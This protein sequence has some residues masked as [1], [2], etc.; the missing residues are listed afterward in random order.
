[1][2]KTYQAPVI[3]VVDLQTE[4]VM[5]VGSDSLNINIDNNNEIDAGDAFSNKHGG[6][7]SDA[8]NATEK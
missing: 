5:M 6:W 1:M 7:N 8:W 3:T 2:R 4:S